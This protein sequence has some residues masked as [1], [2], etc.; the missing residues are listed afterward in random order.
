MSDPNNTFQPVELR[1]VWF[2]LS[3]A[4]SKIHAGEFAQRLKEIFDGQSNQ[5]PTREGMIYQLEP[6]V[7]V[8]ND[9]STGDNDFIVTVTR[10]CK[11]TVTEDIWHEEIIEA[12][13][14]QIHNRIRFA[15]NFFSDYT[16]FVEG[17]LA[18]IYVLYPPSEFGGAGSMIECPDWSTDG[19]AKVFDWFYRYGPLTNMTV[20]E[21]ATK[22]GR[23]YGYVRSEKSKYDKAHP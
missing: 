8:K 19:K 7:V 16:Q 10:R 5:G 12:S 13:V 9:S 2:V 23:A 4:H 21:L 18:S 17:V 14:H 15:I 11:N 6:A 1:Q 22:V 20:K 3:D